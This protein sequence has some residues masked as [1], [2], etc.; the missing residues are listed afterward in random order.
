M[1]SS[2]LDRHRQPRA[3]LH[4]LQRGNADERNGRQA[5]GY[6]GSLVDSRRLKQ[7]GSGLQDALL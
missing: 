6:L 2:T 3:L 7:A 5:W 1:Y 4:L